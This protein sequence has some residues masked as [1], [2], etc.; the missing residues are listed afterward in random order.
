MESSFPALFV[1]RP[2]GDRDGSAD[3]PHPAAVRNGTGLCGGKFQDVFSPL[4]G[5]GDV[6]GLEEH[7]VVAAVDAAGGGVNDPRTGTPAWDR[8]SPWLWARWLY[9]VSALAAA[10]FTME[11]SPVFT[12]L[13]IPSAQTV[14][15]NLRPAVS[16]S[17]VRSG[18]RAFARAE[19]SAAE[20]SPAN[21]GTGSAPGRAENPVSIVVIVLT[22]LYVFQHCDGVVCQNSGGA[23]QR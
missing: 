19:S 1:L 21:W 20:G 2:T 8:G 4:E 10:V 12:S 3:H 23:V 22:H 5:V 17:L 13:S 15:S 6:V 18:N 16:K 9:A 11:G 7:F 14:G